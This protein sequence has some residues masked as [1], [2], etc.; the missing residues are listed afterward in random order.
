MSPTYDVLVVG[1]GLSGLQAALTLH[2]AGLSY[3]V[4]EARD[5]VGGKVFT[6]RSPETGAV[7]SDL[8]A[9][10]INDSNQNQMWSLAKILGLETFV[11][12]TKGDVVVQDFDGS[13]IKFP[14]GDAPK[15]PSAEDTSSCV[16]IRDEVERLSTTQSSSILSAGRHRQQLDSMSFETYL[17]NAKVTEKAFAT[18]QVWT[19]AML[20]MDPSEISAL[21][22]IEYCAAGG[23]L[24][25]M[26]SDQKDG[27]QYLRIRQGM[28]AF[29][30]G[31]ARKLRPGSVKLCS[32]VASIS[33][34]SD[35]MVSVSTIGRSP[36]T[37][38]ARKVIISIPTP[39]YKTISFEPPLPPSKTAVV[40]RTRYGFYTK[41][42]ITFSR[43]FWTEKSLCGLAQSFTGPVSVFR[44]TSLGEQ[45]YCLT[46][47]LGGQFGRKWAAQDAEAK[48]SSVL[49]QISDIFADGQDIAPL[50]IEAHESPWMEEEYS[51]WG[52]PC[53]TMPPGVLAD[54]WEALCA[55]VGNLHFV[56]TE[57][58]TV[59]RGY[60]EGAV[61]TGERGAMEAITALKGNKVA[62]RL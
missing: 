23:G 44:D 62:A 46:C 59:W 32:P 50:F 16:S 22:F 14:Y 9:A 18:A 27:G 56:G 58:S 38:H 47:F 49:K 42:I 37:Y 53:P 61:R 17:R 36:K 3:V 41:Y 54:G 48:R 33:Q 20:G 7:K 60:M 1:A 35:G 45:S 2:A 6:L 10:W 39:V 12:N 5:R 11:Q 43:P 52:C 8:G 26:R 40:N 30:E 57:L 21:Y 31:L 15:Y 55:P 29:P 4:L 34:D 25:T 51:G 24:M 19:H 13:L 28:S